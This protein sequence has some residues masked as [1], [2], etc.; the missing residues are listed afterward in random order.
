MVVDV[1][2]SRRRQ[3]KTR[4]QAIVRKFEIR[5]QA[6]SLAELAAIGPGADL[7]LRAVEENTIQLVAKGLSQYCASHGMDEDAGVLA[8]A[9]Q[10]HPIRL[11]PRLDPYVGCVSGIGIALFAYLRM[12]SGV[13]ALKPDGRVRKSLDKHG[14]SVP[15]GSDAA[16]I[17]LAEAVA[18]ELG[19]TL[20]ALDQVLW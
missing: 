16:L 12:R 20:L 6:G 10:Q 7:G 1:V 2:A 19:I 18:E 3:Y 8:W 9:Q 4:V 5:S 17:L 14:F 11:A 15:P 13:D